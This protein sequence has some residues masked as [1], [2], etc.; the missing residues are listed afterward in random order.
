MNVTAIEIED[1]VE[2]ALERC[3]TT[4]ARN[5]QRAETRA[6]AGPVKPTPIKAVAKPRPAAARAS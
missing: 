2:K 6:K 3:F 4:K 1:R 5:A